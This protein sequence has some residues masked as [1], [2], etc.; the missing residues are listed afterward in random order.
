MKLRG[1][2][3][4][5]VLFPVL[6]FAGDRGLGWA[7]GRVLL[8]SE[9]R[10]SRLYRGGMDHEI[11]LLG[12]SYTLNSFHAPTIERLTGRRTFN[13]SYTGLSTEVAE[14]FFLDYV[15]RNTP[16][17]VLV[18]ELQSL[19][20]STASL[21]PLLTPYIHHSDRIR[22]LVLR[23]RPSNVRLAQFSWLFS[24]NGEFF[25][26]ALYY[27]GRNDQDWVNG[28]TLTPGSLALLR[29]ME[30]AEMPAA[31][32]EN[33]AALD[34]MISLALELGIEVRLVMGPMH[35]AYREKLLNL[36]PWLQ[37]VTARLGAR[38]PIVDCTTYLDD[39]GDF[40]D[41]AHTNRR[42]AIKLD[43]RLFA[44]GF[45]DLRP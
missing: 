12:N 7:L 13:L 1:S 16:P 28:Q 17:K 30:P 6:L 45:F 24:Y 9:M 34:R 29:S 3:W 27:L 22:E 35:P 43:E 25:L 33:V 18:T 39:D 2:W 37:D 23:H 8:S 10:Y 31:I 20:S 44:E 15:D 21:L 32:P 5:L 40:A 19:T 26:R 41:R 11:L 42:G 38:L 36:E 4:L 14:A